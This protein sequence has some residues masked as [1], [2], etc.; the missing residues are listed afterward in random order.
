[1]IIWDRLDEIIIDS[2]SVKNGLLKR[3][4]NNPGFQSK[5]RK[6]ELNEE[7]NLTLTDPSSL[8]EKL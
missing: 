1:M 6:D 2:A 4:K 8:V 5:Q 3:M 7:I